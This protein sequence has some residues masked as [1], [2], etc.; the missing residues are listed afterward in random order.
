MALKNM[1]KASLL[2]ISPMAALGNMYVKKIISATSCIT[3][4]T[5]KS[6]LC[7]WVE[8]KSNLL[9]KISSHSDSQTQIKCDCY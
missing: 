1:S 2:E 5:V 9:F 4:F 8:I 3:F 6:F 7:A